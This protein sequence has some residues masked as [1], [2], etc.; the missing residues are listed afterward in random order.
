MN[1]PTP[2]ATPT[3]DIMPT[4]IKTTPEGPFFTN[5]LDNVE[6]DEERGRGEVGKR[7]GGE[8]REGEREGGGGKE[9]GRGREGG[10]GREGKWEGEGGREG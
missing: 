3:A 10:K 4:S 1:P 7:E 9:G 6:V 5:L 2:A 8:G